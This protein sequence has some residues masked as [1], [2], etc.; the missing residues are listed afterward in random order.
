MAAVTETVATVE[1]IAQTAEQSNVRSKAVAESS[2]RAVDNGTAGRKAVEDAIAA[3]SDVKVRAES[4]AQNILALSERA[5]AIGDIITVVNDVA[6]QTNMLALNAAIEASRAGEHGRGFHVVAS[7]IKS[8]A[9]QSKKATVQVRGILGEI[10]RSTNSAVM[11]TEDGSKAVDLA[12]RTVN[13]ADDALRVLADTIMEAA[14]ASMQISAS[15][16]QQAIGM[17]QIRQ[18]MRNVREASTQHLAS[19]Q[20]T[21]HAARDLDTVG[22]RLRTLLRGANA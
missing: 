17:T 2:Q 3:M 19:A 13:L 8:L 20:Q 5:Q 22:S 7:E 11:A 16:G 1:E 6:E 12:V 21:E 4:V 18:A 9:Q 15:V 14:Q 10:Q